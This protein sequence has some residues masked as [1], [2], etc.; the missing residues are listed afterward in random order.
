MKIKE[1][2][3]LCADL[4]AMRRFYADTLGLQVIAAAPGSCSFAVGGSVLT[5]CEEKDTAAFYHFAMN[6]VPQQVTTAYQWTMARLPLL[7]AKEGTTLVDFPNWNAKAFYF[8][9]PQQNIV[10]CIARFDLDVT[11]G[12]AGR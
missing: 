9:D 4:E 7:K 11:A 3:L 6:I 8:L 12:V 5:F 10:E 1:L 2:R